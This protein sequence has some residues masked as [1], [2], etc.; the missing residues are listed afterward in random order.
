MYMNLYKNFQKST[1]LAA[2]INPDASEI[3][4]EWSILMVPMVPSIK[5]TQAPINVL[6]MS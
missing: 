4:P 3:S 6:F 5:E 2:V 1:A